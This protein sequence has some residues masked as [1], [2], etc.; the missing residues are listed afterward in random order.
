MKNAAWGPEDGP[1]RAARAALSAAKV[2]ER[3]GQKRD[4]NFQRSS[5]AQSWTFLV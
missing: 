5:A 1:E 4:I 2:G 3:G